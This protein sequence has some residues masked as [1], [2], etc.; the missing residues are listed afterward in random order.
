MSLVSNLGTYFQSLLPSFKKKD[1]V[2]DMSYSIDELTQVIKP[3]FVSVQDIKLQGEAV[4]FANTHFKRLLDHPKATAYDKFMDTIETILENEE[5]IAEMLTKEFHDENIKSVSDYHKLNVLK[6]VEALHLFNNYARMWINSAIYET[7]KVDN[8]ELHSVIKSPTLMNDAKFVMNYD[9]TSAVA[10]AINMLS[11][12]VSKFLDEI[13]NLKGHV[14]NEEDWEGG[15]SII[16]A[17]LDPFKSNFIPVMWNPIYHI[18]L[19]ANA[20]RV[21]RYERNKAE[22]ARLQLMIMGLKESKTTTNNSERISQLE[23]QINYYSNLSN[24]ISAKI[25]KMEEKD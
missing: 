24:K 8:S 14:F 1:I 5:A 19:I 25:E 2:L 21:E 3:M 12:P 10:S 11:I 16:N 9:N 7:S 23:K 17:K 13:K 6:Y 4:N 22:L 20:W 18:G 15:S